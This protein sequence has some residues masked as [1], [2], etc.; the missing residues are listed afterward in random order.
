MIN[1]LS[2]I[3]VSGSNA[4]PDV[5]LVWTNRPVTPHHPLDFAAL[6][7]AALR[8]GVSGVTVTHNGDSVSFGVADF[9]ALATALGF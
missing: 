6:A 2:V 4:A 7:E 1:P 8:A 5:D 9:G 3:R